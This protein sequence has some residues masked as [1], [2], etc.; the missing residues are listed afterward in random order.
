M[1]PLLLISVRPEVSRALRFQRA[2][3]ET[4]GSRQGRWRQPRSM[5]CYRVERWLAPVRS[6]TRTAKRLKKQEGLTMS[7][8]LPLLP[9]EVVEIP[10]ELRGS[11]GRIVGQTASARSRPQLSIL[12]GVLSGTITVALVDP[13]PLG[14]LEPILELGPT[15]FPGLGYQLLVG[16]I[17]IG[18]VRGY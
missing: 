7:S 12:A 14:L 18:V 1:Q 2:Q 10:L 3:S 5:D 6:T 4:G 11:L 17:Q 15:G 8:G 13:V 9:S 16:P